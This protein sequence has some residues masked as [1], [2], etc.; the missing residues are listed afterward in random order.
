M[1]PERRVNNFRERPV[2]GTI[3]T[4]ALVGVV[5][6]G[7]A[8]REEIDGD[9]KSDVVPV[10]TSATIVFEGNSCISESDRSYLDK[11]LSIVDL[12]GRSSATPVGEGEIFTITPSVETPG[13]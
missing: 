1:D 4:L 6:W 7:V 8:N 5:A 11:N 9:R 3:A 13:C 2:A 10:G 12:Q